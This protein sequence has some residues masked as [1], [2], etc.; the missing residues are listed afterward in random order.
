MLDRTLACRVAAAP[1]THSAQNRT[2]VLRRRALALAGAAAMLLGAGNAL[3]DALLTPSGVNNNEEFGAALS[4]C[5]PTSG[6]ARTLV[7]AYNDNDKGSSSGS[8][9]LYERQADG[10]WA[11]ATELL[12]S[13]G[14]A[15]D[16]FGYAVGVDGDRAVV[17]AFKDDD[18][19]S[20]SG[21]AYVF[22]RQTNGTWTQAAKLLASDGSADDEF[23]TAV[24]VS[25]TRILVGGPKNDDKGA[26]SGSAYVFERQTN[27]TWQQVAKLLA[28]D[29]AASDFLGCAVAI[30]GTIAALGA[31]EQD[32]TASNSGAVYV[33]ERQSNG[34]WSQ[35]AKLK[36]S[37]AQSGD[38]FG[39][40]VALRGSVLAV[41]APEDDD[42]GSNGGSVYVF[43]RQSNGAWTQ[44][45]KLLAP[46]PD[47]DA[48]DKLGSSVAT[49]GWHVLAGAPVD[50]PSIA[51]AAYL[52][53]YQAGTGW[54]YRSRLTR[55]SGAASDE[56]GTSVALDGDDAFGGAPGTDSGAYGRAGSVSVQVIENV[57]TDMALAPSW[58]PSG[59]AGATVGTLSTTDADTSES[60]SYAVTTD[61]SGLFE[62]SGATLRLKS[63]QSANWAT[64]P[65]HTVQLTVTDRTAHTYAESF[66]I[67][68]NRLPTANAQSLEILDATSVAIVLSGSDPDGQ[69]LTYEITQNPTSGTLSGTPPN[70]T[71]SP[72]G[73]AT[74]AEFQFRVV[75]ELDGA[76][77]PA[78]VHIDLPDSDDNGLPDWWQS[79][80]LE[81]W[82]GSGGEVVEEGPGMDPEGD[83]DDDGLTNSQECAAGTHPC[84]PDSDDDGLLDG[85]EAATAGM[86]PLS[87]NTIQ[88][89]LNA[90]P[91]GDTVVL[92]PGVYE[93]QI[94]MPGHAVILRGRT[95]A[96]PA[97]AEAAVLDGISASGPVVTFVA[98]EAGASSTP[99]PSIEGLTIR[100]GGA[101][102]GGAVYCAADS[103][104]AVR[105]CVLTGNGASDAGGAVYAAPDSNVILERCTISG[106]DADKGAG[107]AGNGASLTLVNCYVTGNGNQPLGC[108]CTKGGGM[109]VI[110]G[111]TL[112]IECCTIAA[113]DASDSG[114]G[115]WAADGSALVLHNTIVYANTGP[116]NGTTQIRGPEGSAA[117]DYCC[118]EGGWGSGVGNI[119]DDPE[120]LDPDNGDFS[121]TG[122]SPCVDAGSSRTEAPTEDRSREPRPCAIADPPEQYVEG[123]DIGADEYSYTV[124]VTIEDASGAA[125][126]EFNGTPVTE[127]PDDEGP[128]STRRRYSVPWGTS[129]SVTVPALPL[130][131]PFGPLS[132]YDG[133]SRYTLVSIAGTGSAPALTEQSRVSFGATV[134]SQVTLNWDV[135]HFLSVASIGIDPDYV[136]CSP[137]P[138]NWYSQDTIVTITAEPDP[139]VTPTPLPLSWV[140][141]VATLADDQPAQPTGGAAV[142]LVLSEPIHAVAV[143]LSNT[144]DPTKGS[145]GNGWDF[146]LDLKKGWNLVSFPVHADPAATGKGGLPTWEEIRT[147]TQ[148]LSAIQGDKPKKRIPV[149]RRLYLAESYP[150]GRE[151]VDQPQT[152]KVYWVKAKRATKV[153]VPASV[154]DPA[155]QDLL[156]GI[157]D[158]GGESETWQWSAFTFTAT[159][160]YPVSFP[161]SLVDLR[162]P[163]DF[164]ADGDIQKLEGKKMVSIIAGSGAER[165][166]EVRQGQGYWLKAGETAYTWPE[167]RIPLDH[168][169][170]GLF[171][172]WELYFGCSEDDPDSDGD[173]LPDGWEATTPGGN[174]SQDTGVIVA[175]EWDDTEDAGHWRVEDPSRGSILWDGDSESLIVGQFWSA[176]LSPLGVGVV[177]ES[178]WFRA[179][180]PMPVQ[181]AAVAFDLYGD[182]DQLLSV[183]LRVAAGGLTWTSQELLDDEVPEVVAD[184]G[185]LRLP[186]LCSLDDSVWPP[187][188]HA[189]AFGGSGGTWSVDWLA[190]VVVRSEDAAATGGDIPLDNLRLLTADA[191]TSF[192][193]WRRGELGKGIG[194]VGWRL[195]YAS[196]ETDDLV[197]MREDTWDATDA[198]VHWPTVTVYA[199][200]PVRITHWYSA[201]APVGRGVDLPYDTSDE[202][203]RFVDITDISLA[204][205]Q[206]HVFSLSPDG[207]IRHV[208]GDLAREYRGGRFR[209]KL[210]YEYPDVAGS[211]VI[212]PTSGIVN[213][214]FFSTYNTHSTA[215]DAEIGRLLLTL[216][217]S[218]NW[219]PAT[220]PVAARSIDAV[221]KEK[222]RLKYPQYTPG[223]DPDLRYAVQGDEGIIQY[224]LQRDVGGVWVDKWAGETWPPPAEW[225][226]PW[227]GDIGAVWRI[228]VRVIFYN[229][230]PNYSNW[231]YA[232][233][234]VTENSP[235]CEISPQCAGPDEDLTA[236]VVRSV[237]AGNGDPLTSYT[238]QWGRFA[239]CDAPEPIP[240]SVVET[241]TAQLAASNTTMGQIWRVRAR[242]AGGG[243]GDWGPWSANCATIETTTALAAPTVS[244][245][246]EPVPP[247][248]PVAGTSTLQASISATPVPSGCT[249]YAYWQGMGSD[250]QW[251]AE[252]SRSDYHSVT[253]QDGVGQDS[254]GGLT[255]GQ[256]WRCWGYYTIPGCS[257]SVPSPAAHSAAVAIR[258]AAPSVSVSVATQGRYRVC[259]TQH[260]ENL[261][262]GEVYATSVVTVSGPPGATFAWYRGGFLIAAETEDSL[263]FATAGFQKGESW[264]VHVTVS[265]AALDGSTVS[266]VGEAS[267]VV[268]DYHPSAALDAL[269][270][271]VFITTADGTEEACPIRP[272]A[273]AIRALLR[274]LPTACGIHDDV[275]NEEYGVAMGPVAY[276]WLYHTPPP[277]P[278]WGGPLITGDACSGLQGSGWAGY[279]APSSPAKDIT[280]ARE[281]G[282]TWW[283]KASCEIS[284][285]SPGPDPQTVSTGTLKDED[286]TVIYD[287]IGEVELK[288]SI[289]PASPTPETAVFRAEATL[290][291]GEAFTPMLSYAWSTGTGTPL[292]T[293]EVLS[294]ASGALPLP[295]GMLI[296][297]QV[298]ASFADHGQ[299]LE[300]QAE[301]TVSDKLRPP[302]LD[303]R[304]SDARSMASV[305]DPVDAVT[306][307]FWDGGTFQVPGQMPLAVSWRYSSNDTGAGVLG[308]GWRLTPHPELV[309]SSEDPDFHMVVADDGATITLVDL[310]PDDSL[311]DVRVRPED[312]T[313]IAHA[314]GL[315]GGL[316]HA[317]GAGLS[318]DSGD[319]LYRYRTPEGDVWSFA[320]TSD[321]SRILLVE[322]TDPTGN[323]LVFRYDRV[324]WQAAAPYAASGQYR[325]DLE[326]LGNTNLGQLVRIENA[327]TGRTVD[328]RYAEAGDGTIRLDWVAELRDGSAYGRRVDFT[329]ARYQGTGPSLLTG[330]ARSQPCQPA[331][332]SAP[333]G[334]PVGL[335]VGQSTA[336]AVKDAEYVYEY[337]GSPV[338]YLITESRRPGGAGLVNVYDATGRVTEQ[339]MLTTGAPVAGVTVTTFDYGTAGETTVT[340]WRD[341]TNW[342]QSL[343]TYDGSGRVT[344]IAE[345]YSGTSAASTTFSWN[346]R[347][348]L[349]QTVGPDNTV[350]THA[351]DTSPP[352]RLRS[353][354][355]TVYPA[356]PG[357]PAINGGLVRTTYHYFASVPETALLADLSRLA[358]VT[359]ETADGTTD[360]QVLTLVR[361]TA[362]DWAEDTGVLLSEATYEGSAPSPSQ[363]RTWEYY[364]PGE[365]GQLNLDPGLMLPKS[366]TVAGSAA[367]DSFTTYFVPTADG[368]PAQ[369]TMREGGS[370]DGAVIAS[371]AFTYYPDGSLHTVSEGTGSGIVTSF[372]YDAKGRRVA[373]TDPDG[374]T[375][376]TEYDSRGNATKVLGPR[377]DLVGADLSTMDY[378]LSD[379]LLAMARARRIPGPEPTY[380]DA[381]T[382]SFAYDYWGRPT[383]MTDRTGVET[384][385]AFDHRGRLTTLKVDVAGLARGTQWTYDDTA[386]TTTVTETM[387][388][389][390]A[391]VT[392]GT[393]DSSALPHGGVWRE[394]RP[395][396]ATTNRGF[397]P[398]GRLIWEEDPERNRTSYTYDALDRPTSMVRQAA[399]GTQ[400][401]Y[402]AWSYNA[403]GK[404]VAEWQ[405][406]EGSRQT[407]YTYDA[408]GR[409][410][411]V[412]GPAVDYGTGVRRVGEFAYDT[413]GRLADHRVWRDTTGDDV[414]RTHYRYY[415]SGLVFSVTDPRNT[416]TFFGYNEAGLRTTA[417]RVLVPCTPDAADGC[418]SLE[419]AADLG[420]THASLYAYDVHGRLVTRWE[421]A[422]HGTEEIG[423]LHYLRTDWGYDGE[424]RLTSLVDP[425]GSTWTNTYDALGRLLSRGVTPPT[426]ASAE[427]SAAGFE[428]LTLAYAAFAPDA[429][430][431]VAS[432]VRTDHDPGGSTAS[433]RYLHDARGNLRFVDEGYDSS[434]GNHQRRTKTTYLANDLP[435]GDTVGEG[436]TALT[437]QY[438]YLYDRLAGE[439]RGG[440][441]DRVYAYD[442]YGDLAGVYP[443][444]IGSS[445]TEAQYASGT[446]YAR[447]AHGEVAWELG[448][449]FAIGAAAVHPEV[450]RR[451]YPRG[452]ERRDAEVVGEGAVLRA[453]TASTGYDRAGATDFV[454]WVSPSPELTWRYPY[455]VDS[456][457][458]LGMPRYVDRGRGDASPA[459]LWHLRDEVGNLREQWLA[460]DQFRTEDPEDPDPWRMLLL[461]EDSEGTPPVVCYDPLNHLTRFDA[462]APS[463]APARTL[464]TY[465]T[466]FGFLLSDGVATYTYDLFGN[467][468]SRTE[469]TAVETYNY[470]SSHDPLHRLQSV[471]A[472]G[473]TTAF[474]YDAR[475]NLASRTGGTAAT[476]YTWDDADRLT[477]VRPISPAVGQKRVQYEYDVLDRLV[478]RTEETWSGTAWGSPG[479]TR[480]VYDGDL[481]VA[482]FD[483]AGSLLREM[484]W[485]PSAEGGVGGLVLL[486]SYLHTED[487]ERV[488]GI[489]R[490]I[491]DFRGNVLALLDESGDIAES[492]G[493]DGFGR[494]A[495][496]DGAGNAITASAVGNPFGFACKRYD[497]T[498]ALYHFGARWYDPAL[499]RFISPDPL[500]FVDGPNRYAYCAGDPVN[501]VDPWGLCAG[502]TSLD[503]L[504]AL[505]ALTRIIQAAQSASRPAGALD[506]PRA[507]AY[508]EFVA[509]P[510]GDLRES[511]QAFRED[512]DLPN[513]L[514]LYRATEQA[515]AILMMLV[516]GPA[517]AR[518][519]PRPHRDLVAD[520]RTRPQDWE[521]T[522]AQVGETPSGQH[523]GGVNI[524]TQW[525][526]TLTGEELSVHEAWRPDGTSVHPENASP[527]IPDGASIRPRNRAKEL[528]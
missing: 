384:M 156:R 279:A 154:R 227:A 196:A 418:Q 211:Q 33:F 494:M 3:G 449:Q 122:E 522:G 203:P 15:N 423:L 179:G 29:G 272:D 225:A 442:A 375:T 113:N 394:V 128:T 167:M 71:Y 124:E 474:T 520:F 393:T 19:G 484:V 247:E 467:R 398:L 212:F 457:D 333:A 131:P 348:Q 246:W 483:G 312:N 421:Q 519:A 414:A 309:R 8:A 231:V 96:D 426:G 123:V 183:R 300:A 24:A 281:P 72:R 234:T 185:R 400:T 471:T 205:G 9:Y 213:T 111:C 274:A 446:S 495:V 288:V 216:D 139:N 383:G 264:A 177:T 127:A 382:T 460:T 98:T 343:Y 448:P 301:V 258:P 130:A 7:G 295:V 523:R 378:D 490:P 170:D 223:S 284:L 207:G 228:G 468:L 308:P 357:E 276:Q 101:A 132:S 23:G 178:M 387:G 429:D 416:T 350:T 126:I 480:I 386:R 40:A 401:D 109:H 150:N 341:G 347:G 368:A 187:G 195:S 287:C 172:A 507:Q 59:V 427:V 135:E 363:V 466:C 204:A 469:G 441:S 364:A 502:T 482:E 148:S 334:G 282:T 52:F 242:K 497:G 280:E 121:I 302:D 133:L 215:Y 233:F 511:I 307:E 141:T 163:T 76:S 373:A 506:V 496:F 80:Y 306:G 435:L 160:W 94:T 149:D 297:V 188:F 397:D 452:L 268:Q 359:V 202:E 403:L 136:S 338:R 439:T 455:V 313:R 206:T 30:D 458:S 413:A 36:A 252:P 362:Y 420:P 74:S 527:N 277:P 396:D 226:T 218:Q 321:G 85:W 168:D 41:G 525:R 162:L 253:T 192:G 259:G 69:A 51:G 473:V 6:P 155:S 328:L 332:L 355:R 385:A 235:A 90:A 395:G 415:P 166:C 412:K 324:F 152:A 232:Q 428:Y 50:E 327:R 434:T 236:R 138:E 381:L 86:D 176:V 450:T 81:S 323:R 48:G 270:L 137:A 84:D 399:D 117:V 326:S 499:G 526:N 197:I 391:E 263:P 64:S 454:G 92:V 106:N 337:G 45:A 181:P 243:T 331:D 310:S 342:S 161:A 16:W 37:D 140:G 103:V 62:T 447:N 237:L 97:V 456:R 417:L 5:T 371:T 42:Q 201:Y 174:P 518:T 100:N 478:C 390:T 319:V 82:V 372:C 508:D 39:Q 419:R 283:V 115:I 70:V 49:D 503:R 261:N 517:A 91:V 432:V 83:P 369:A 34:T 388:L 510:A 239:A 476:E 142:A 340:A 89:A 377:T 329:Y 230:P 339:R 229:G 244:L 485:D 464:F 296:R 353:T 402:R 453:F 114:G 438:A 53:Q 431:C 260:E 336:Q 299:T 79:V 58:V 463:S 157:T 254:L 180:V 290:V 55:P 164:P 110:Y 425:A 159:H 267:G 144:N 210:V 182:R 407:L 66:T 269:P 17:G 389:G 509:G 1:R 118:I 219:W 462:Q 35:T 238:F 330:V 38:R 376:W 512:P 158:F 314:P 20:S 4:A 292:G 422:D 165:H 28:S 465:S 56:F 209:L 493:Y 318:Y 13:D 273:T 120:F 470:G 208:S 311:T 410:T 255:P 224:R 134:A 61:A 108:P 78:T 47:G 374:H 143:A 2:G 443:G 73:L 404:V 266:S 487:D 335:L 25:G 516:P 351:Y 479:V 408:A 248:V 65:T 221:T 291:H 411:E 241:T 31:N 46:S 119:T 356:S 521:R 488:Y 445:L 444:V 285:Q 77:A 459:Y 87:A 409:V 424:G 125:V 191:A 175:E 146:V 430:G 265:L 193:A 194:D 354:F 492:Y 504:R 43:T 21:S 93:Q 360:A 14:A 200:R 352:Y 303:E 104:A 107:V 217:L 294:F 515:A 304:G 500:G 489:Y 380:E 317:L 293:G 524:E 325:L 95:P 498:T 358:G 220:I 305:A 169:R 406:E 365:L 32:T 361:G 316:L 472:A 256:V 345:D 436:A 289:S 481:P 147:Y 475:G 344:S 153:V 75:D 151:P 27:G 440:L 286:G 437:R 10:T 88:A 67:T 315:G 199:K 186:F 271:D 60:F 451:R 11:L 57:P 392:T 461:A 501:F 491:C 528:R 262:D 250:G 379:S 18:S 102:N 433:T 105:D 486:R 514:Y 214:G 26:N 99:A 370:P 68:V 257:T 44:T 240:G 513:A 367:G 366:V 145:E 189:A 63:G 320:P 477:Q 198:S 249:Y 222:D 346:A 54:A 129:V 505:W 251:P 173:L 298:T 184:D 405:D 116:T 190:V 245:S 12:A 278:P 171:D 275:D 349:V 112:T 22:E 322:R